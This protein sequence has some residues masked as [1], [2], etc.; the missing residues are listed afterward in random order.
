MT[1]GGHF[2]QGRN[3]IPSAKSRSSRKVLNVLLVGIAAERTDDII[4]L[5]YLLEF[6]YS[7]VCLHQITILG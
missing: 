4:Q 6:T 1:P 5:Q 3:R 7:H 2:I